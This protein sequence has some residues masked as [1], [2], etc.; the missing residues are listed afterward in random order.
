VL[1]D[2][3]IMRNMTGRELQQLRKAARV[4]GQLVADQAGW[5]HRA[6]IS[7]IEALAQVPPK[8]AQRYL[9]ALTACVAGRAA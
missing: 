5:Q 8:S 2:K 7:Q 4:S 3:R 1:H 6:R 9:E